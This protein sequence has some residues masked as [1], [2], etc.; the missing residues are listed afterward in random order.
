MKYGTA[1]IMDV[2]R[3][4]IMCPLHDFFVWKTGSIFLCIDEFFT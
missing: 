4:F 1:F 3:D 2:L